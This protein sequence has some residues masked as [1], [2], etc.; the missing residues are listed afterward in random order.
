MV[1]KISE[2]VIKAGTGK[3]IEAGRATPGPVRAN[4]DDL[5]RQVE[6][7]WGRVAAL[8][9]RLA[10]FLSS[11]ANNEIVIRAA[12]RITLDAQEIQLTGPGLG[13]DLRINAG[14]FRVAAG[15]IDMSADVTK[16]N[17]TTLELSGDAIAR[18]STTSFRVTASQ[19]KFD[20]GIAEA[21]GLIKCQTL[22]AVN[23]VGSS[24]TPGAGNIW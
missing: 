19:V 7:L 8:E 1:V 18:L 16:I 17:G 22:Q 9:A 2:L 11:G 21:S 3:A 14:D 23:V 6:A 15:K 24:Y 5:A 20:C 13:C 10:G 12:G 4:A